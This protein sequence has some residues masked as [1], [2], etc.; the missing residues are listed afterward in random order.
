MLARATIVMMCLVAGAGAIASASKGEAVPLRA[1]LD[2]LTMSFEGWTGT[3]A[4]RFDARTMEILGVDEYIHRVYHS[5]ARYPVFLYIGFYG[6]QSQGDTMHSPLNCLPASGWEPVSRERRTVQI[7]D[8]PNGSSRTI[9]VNQLLIQKGADRQVVLY[10]YQSRDRVT[11][12]EYWSKLL[13]VSDAIRLNRTDGA[14][15]RVVAPVAGDPAV[16][17]Q[18]AEAFVRKMFPKLRDHL[19]S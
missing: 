18:Q 2:E 11:A 3:H 17:S 5:S 4:A 12:N 1:R 14:I 8:S 7:P 13:T 9:E 15:V 19:P 16:A 10:W 6:N